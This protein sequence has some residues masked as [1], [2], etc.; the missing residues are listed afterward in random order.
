VTSGD[1]ASQSLQQRR[2]GPGHDPERA[3][4]GRRALNNVELGLARD[5]APGREHAPGPV[6][7][8]AADKIQN[9]IDRAY[10]IL[11]TLGR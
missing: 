2:I 4:P 9:E 5:G 1:L 3:C 7:R 8:L 11:E 6:E 10:A